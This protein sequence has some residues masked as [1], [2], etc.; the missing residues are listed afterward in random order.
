MRLLGSECTREDC[1]L[2]TTQAT[3][4]GQFSHC[5][6]YV[7]RDV[8]TGLAD[9]TFQAI[10]V[11]FWRLAYWQLSPQPAFPSCHFFCARGMLYHPLS[12]VPGVGVKGIGAAPMSEPGHSRLLPSGQWAA[13][14]SLRTARKRWGT[15]EGLQQGGCSCPSPEPHRAGTQVGDMRPRH[16]QASW[17]VTSAWRGST[18]IQTVRKPR[19]TQLS[20]K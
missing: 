6:I 10:R 9:T 18:R 7:G 4:T 3:V 17:G 11:M 12:G 14:W 1:S 15:D 19:K 5:T 8:E 2:V 13:P 16:R 20:S